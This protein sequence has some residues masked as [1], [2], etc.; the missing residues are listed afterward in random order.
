MQGVKQ[1]LFILGACT[2]RAQFQA[3][4]RKRKGKVESDW[5]KY[6]IEVSNLIY[7]C[8]GNTLETNIN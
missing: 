8:S 5:V 3:A 4:E 2:S 7:N 1:K 6:Q